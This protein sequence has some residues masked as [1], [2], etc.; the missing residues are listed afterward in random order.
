MAGLYLIT[1]VIIAKTREANQGSLCYVCPME[2]FTTLFT[3]LWA[4]Q[5]HFF[6]HPF[7][8]HNRYGFLNFTV[9]NNWRVTQLF[10]HQI[11]LLTLHL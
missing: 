7:C 10:F 2:S 5:T 3:E 9:A 6:L 8:V 11:H 1:S 4:A